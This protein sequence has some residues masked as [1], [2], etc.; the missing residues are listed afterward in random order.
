MKQEKLRITSHATVIKQAEL[1]YEDIASTKGIPVIKPI[2]EVT[3]LSEGKELLF[4][5]SAFEYQVLE[6]GQAGSLVYEAK[7]YC[8]ELISFTDDAGNELIK[9]WKEE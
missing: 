6:V 2:Y 4:S 9:E 5:L 8:N 7:K 1:P 3:F